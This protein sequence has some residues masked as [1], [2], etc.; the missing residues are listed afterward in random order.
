[1]HASGRD[2]APFAWL[3]GRDRSGRAL[4]FRPILV[5]LSVWLVFLGTVLIFKDR[6]GS[7]L[8]VL[9]FLPFFM[10]GTFK[11]ALASE[12]TR[13][14]QDDH[15]SGALELLLVTPLPPDAILAGL[16]Q[17]T[18]RKFLPVLILLI[19]VNL[20]LFFVGSVLDLWDLPRQLREWLAIVCLGGIA[21]LL[22]DA[23]A[24]FWV[25]L[26]AALRYPTHNR[27][28]VATLLR[29]LLP[30]WLALLTAFL[31]PTLMGNNLSEPP[32]RAFLCAWFVFG[33]IISLALAQWAQS[34]LAGQFRRFA[35]GER[36]RPHPEPPPAAT[37]P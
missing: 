28:V 6:I 23:R 10:H 1:L 11:L 20:T 22:M 5:L 27:A 21:L 25:S 34:T 16:H 24:L 30:S 33:G 8:A 9:F 14:L 13:R 31:L 29:V 2:N 32:V 37:S 36:T 15:R 19:G 26:W 17:A 12:S 18:R 4:I 3:V 7:L 35:A